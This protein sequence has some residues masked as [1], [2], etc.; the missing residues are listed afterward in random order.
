M[1]LR[2]LVLFWAQNIKQLIFNL[3]NKFHFSAAQLPDRYKFEFKNCSNKG[4]FPKRHHEKKN[5][6]KQYFRFL[7]IS[8]NLLIYSSFYNYLRA[9][10][11]LK[12][13][14]KSG[15]RKKKILDTFFDSLLWNENLNNRKIPRI[16]NKRSKLTDESEKIFL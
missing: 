11:Q 8:M 16:L 7:I 13:L 14:K 6:G 15:I 1:I 12:K 9:N 5:F 3:I 2:I 10:F 4:K